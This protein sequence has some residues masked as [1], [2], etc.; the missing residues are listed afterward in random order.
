MKYLVI[1]SDRKSERLEHK[2]LQNTDERC[3]KRS[4]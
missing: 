3:L 1:K 2:K 4:N